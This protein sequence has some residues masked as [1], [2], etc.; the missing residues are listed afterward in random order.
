MMRVGKSNGEKKAALLCVDVCVFLP[1]FEFLVNK[2][3]LFE[4]IG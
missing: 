1:L 3:D 4:P 2:N